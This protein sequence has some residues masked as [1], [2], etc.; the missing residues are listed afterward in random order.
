MVNG[1]NLGSA[2]T[3]GSGVNLQTIYNASAEVGKMVVGGTAATV[4]LGG[5][6][7]QGGGHSAFSPTLGLAADN[8]IRE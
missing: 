4:A 2:V 8:A 1:T 6:Y 3:V 7:I 5:G